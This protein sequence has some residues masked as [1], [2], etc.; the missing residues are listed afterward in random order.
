[1]PAPFL[2]SGLH[3]PLEI[4][5]PLVIVLFVVRIVMRRRRGEPALGGKVVVRCR[6]G[7][8]FR[9]TWSPFGSFTSIRLGMA[10]YQYC[11][12]G[13]H[14]SLCQPV[15]DDE[16]TSEERRTLDDEDRSNPSS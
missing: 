1:V 12:V 10:R 9:T 14:W 3:A 8:V 5:L 16:L 2:A 11:P 15:K 7:H 6:Q 4:A 13:G